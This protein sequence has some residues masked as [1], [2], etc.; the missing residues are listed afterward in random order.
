MLAHRGEVVGSLM[1][2]LLPMNYVIRSWKL[3]SLRRLN[4]VK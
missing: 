1:C 2:A 3:N 4:E